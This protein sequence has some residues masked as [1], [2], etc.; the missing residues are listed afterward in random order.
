MVT[1]PGFFLQHR[2]GVA[3]MYIARLIDRVWNEISQEEMLWLILHTK[4]ILPIAISP[5]STW[6]SGSVNQVLQF[7]PASDIYPN[8]VFY[9]YFVLKSDSLNIQVDSAKRFL[10]M[11]QN[12]PFGLDTQSLYR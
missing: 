3:Y 7:H 10:I 2:G 12:V 5:T 6:Y 9:K 8:C 1:T 4:E 11:L